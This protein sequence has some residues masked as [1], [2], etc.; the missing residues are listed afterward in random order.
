MYQSLRGR[1]FGGLLLDLGIERFGYQ[2]YEVAVCLWVFGLEVFDISVIPLSTDRTQLLTTLI[3]T[4][5]SGAINASPDAE[6]NDTE[7]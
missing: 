2:R 6:H 1:A 7:N 3:P 4:Q 5:A